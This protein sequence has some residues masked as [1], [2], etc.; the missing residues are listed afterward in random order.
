[1]NNFRRPFGRIATLAVWSFLF[2][3]TAGTAF[4]AGWP[5][6]QRDTLSDRI[7]A[8]KP[9]DALVPVLKTNLLFDLAGAPNFGVEIPLNLKFSLTGEAAYAYWRIDNRYALQTMQGGIGLKYWFRLRNGEPLTGWNAG[10]Y[11]VYGGRYDVQWKDGYQGDGFVSTGLSA[12]YAMPVSKRLNLEFSLAAGY[13]HTPEVRH[14]HRPENGHLLW[15]ETRYHVN[16]F[17]LTRVQVNLIWLIEK[18][19]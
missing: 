5:D 3:A 18:R 9:R 12:G 15:Q 14:Y 7:S 4:G 19:K 10:V 1:M 8:T 16:R 13:F 17:S 2:S 11:G 6:P